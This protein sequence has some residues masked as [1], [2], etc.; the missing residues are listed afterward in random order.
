MCTV[1]YIKHNNQYFF[2]SNRDEHINRPSAL[3]PQKHVIGDFQLYYPEDPQANGTWFC[4]KNNGTVCILLNGAKNNHVST[5]RYLKSRGVILL[6]L[7]KQDHLQFGWEALR[8]EN[9][10]PF[11]IIAFAK[12]ILHQMRW[13]GTQKETIELNAD[14]AHI[15]SSATLY[16]DE[17]I[18]QKKSWFE[19]FLVDNN[20]KVD[21][22][23]ILTFHSTT[24]KETTGNGMSINHTDNVIT[25]NITQCVLS[26]ND[27]TLSH[28][29][30]LTEEKTTLK[31]EIVVV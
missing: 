4:I 16:S 7:I 24:K 26:K 13:D 22:N 15:W 12:G 28:V 30:L 27:F 1:T 6:E 2:T 8:L 9:I 14:E 5:G 31:D 11:T 29:D 21:S 19:Q 17:N 25:K 10:E 23:K 18:A 3:H 20:K